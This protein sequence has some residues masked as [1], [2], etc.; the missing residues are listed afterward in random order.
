MRKN[1]IKFLSVAAI[2]LLFA[3]CSNPAKMAKNAQLVGTDCNPK[4]LEVVADEIAA[5]YTMVFPEGY[6]HPKAILEVVPVLVYQGGEVA[7]PA[8]KMQGEKVTDNYQV[9]SNRGGRANNTVKFAYVPGMEKSHLE[10]RVAVWDKLKKINFPAPYKVADGANITYKLVDQGGYLSVAPNQYQKIIREQQEA[11][12]MYAISSSI[13]RS[14]ELTKSEIKEFEAFLAGVNQ[15]ERRVVNNVEIVS[16]ASP[17]GPLALNTK[18]SDDRGKTG[19]ETYDK[20]TKSVPVNAPVEIASTGEDWEGFQQLVAA[21]NI[22]DKELILRVLS[23]Y[24]DPAVREREIK[25]MSVV[26]KALADKVLPELRRTR[27]I[28]NVDYTNYTDEELL[29]L[30]SANIEIMDEEALLYTATLTDDLDEKVTLYKKAA[31]KFSSNHGMINLANTYLQQGKLA[32]AK[33][34]IAR[35]T[36]TE[37]GHYI[38]TSGVIALRE[39]RYSE[40]AGLF[41]K[42]SIPQARYNEGILDILNGKY[43]D[44]ATKLTGAGHVNEGLAYILTGQLDRAATVL[45]DCNCPKG[46]YLKAIIAV[47]RGNLSEVARMLEVVRT[48]ETLATRSENDIEFARFRN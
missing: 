24:S 3:S 34:A 5:T 48:D 18:L 41:A 32:E 47:R 29:R 33:S 14:G 21:S 45:A 42:S 35:S 7:A 36:D 16:Y 44:A 2:G 22:Q 27:M 37:C 20:I 23:M 8:F 31:D 46:S 4:I 12:I 1:L 38:N 40:A 43:N 28:A 26:Y 17:E 19:R 30:A 25:N 6:F 10:L 39:G 15:D 9:V 13:V 11:Q